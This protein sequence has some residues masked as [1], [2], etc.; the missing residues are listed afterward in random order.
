[1]AGLVLGIYGVGDS[2]S[3][4]LA[5]TLHAQLHDVDDKLSFCEVPW[6]DVVAQKPLENGR[7]RLNS[8]RELAS[9]LARVSLI[10]P[11]AAVPPNGRME[12]CLRC[13]R[14]ILFELS[15]I[16]FAVAL[17]AAGIFLPAVKLLNA[18]LHGFTID[19]D[20][21]RF[22]EFPMAWVWV[23]AKIGILAMFL[24]LGLFIAASFA[25]AIVTRSVCPIW[26]GLR[27][28]TVIV[29]RPLVYVFA[30][31]LSLPWRSLA[32]RV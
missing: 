22:K 26:I 11:N 14:W 13:C 25:S 7:L 3:G 19:D 2:P 32:A 6:N 5:H 31:P 10:C 12:L 8:I 17:L 29:L 27:R 28:A 30:L 16:S 23:V 24:A 4:R 21:S 1:M 18:E 15:E 9:R 20:L